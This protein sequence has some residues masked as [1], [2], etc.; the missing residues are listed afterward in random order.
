MGKEFARGTT[1]KHTI[2]VVVDGVPVNLQGH[3][4]LFT[5]RL[6]PP[7]DGTTDTAPNA[8][9]WQGDN[10]ATGAA[11]AI[12]T[13]AAV[14]T[15]GAAVTVDTSYTFPVVG[16]GYFYRVA[17]AGTGHIG[18]SQPTWPTVVGQSTTPD[19]NGVVWTCAGAWNACTGTMPPSVTQSLPNPVGSDMPLLYDVVI[20][21]PAGN[22]WQHEAGELL[23]T[24]RATLGQPT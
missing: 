14:W 12:P 1:W 16:N 20:K 11:N 15:S 3:H 17:N 8:P 24:W 7:I 2:H 9:L 6:P 10:E 13:A 21:D 5:V 23:M 22:I 18:T 4:V 19:S